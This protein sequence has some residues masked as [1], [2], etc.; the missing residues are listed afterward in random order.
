MM[1]APPSAVICS[2]TVSVPSTVVMSAG[3]NSSAARCFHGVPADRADVC[4]GV[5]QACG[6]GGAGSPCAAGDERALAGEM[7][8]LD[9]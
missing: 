1:S 2:I 9:A 3:A 6:Y 7:L 5:L 4:P 8:G